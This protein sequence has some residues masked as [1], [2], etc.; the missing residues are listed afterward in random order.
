MTRSDL[1]R[2]V[3]GH[4]LLGVAAGIALAG[5][6][7]AYTATH[8]RKFKPED[9]AE[10]KDPARRALREAFT[11]FVQEEATIPS[12]FGYPLHGLYLP[13]EGAQVTVIL[14]HGIGCDLTFAARYVTLFRPYGWNVLLVDHRHHGQSGGRNTTFGYY[15]KHD[16]LAWADWARTRL[17]PEGKIGVHGESLG[18]AVALQYA[19]LDP[20]LA[21]CIADC[22]YADLPALFVLR[23]RCDY[24]LPAFPFY[25]VASLESRLALGMWFRQ[26]S[27]LR[28]IG[29]VQA[30]VLFIHGREDYF[31]PP[32]H[33]V[34]LFSA[35]QGAKQLYLAP[36][37]G[38]AQSFWKDEAAYR[39][40]VEAFLQE[41]GVQ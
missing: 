2:R 30:P 26:A 7:L 15:E 4:S 25:F 40:E 1:L 17:P 6:W 12:P 10:S 11:Q 13:Q 41:C 32:A 27:P 14:C 29:R 37:A 31:I 21:F 34:Q 33:S 28:S 22:S 19:A 20:Q 18:A 8:P 5:A 36:G 16:L 3:L 9:F 39:A 24:N 38:H 35:K 23:L